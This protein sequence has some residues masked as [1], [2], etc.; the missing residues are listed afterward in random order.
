[1]IHLKNLEALTP[2]SEDEDEG[3]VFEDFYPP[4]GGIFLLPPAIVLGMGHSLAAAPL[5]SIAQG[6]ETATALAEAVSETLDGKT[7]AHFTEVFQFLWIQHFKP[8]IAATS[9]VD[10]SLLSVTNVPQKELE[11]NDYDVTDSQ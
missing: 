1:M 11:A 4:V 3:I 5:V 7:M 10:F 2:E 6:F 9:A 8:K